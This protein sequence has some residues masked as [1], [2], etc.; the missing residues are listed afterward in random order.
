MSSI[1]KF[2]DITN[3]MIT[4]RGQSVIFDCDV[5]ELYGVET[6]EINEAVKNNPRKFPAEFFISL[7]DREKSE[8]VGK[9]QNFENN[10]FS[11]ALSQAF[12]TQGCY[13]LATLLQTDRAIGT[14]VDIIKAFEKLPEFLEII[15]KR[16]QENDCEEQEEIREKNDIRF[17]G[18]N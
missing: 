1:V 4:V 16:V 12:T 11:T 18:L 15:S 9:F 2:S 17:L 13:M 3:K 7:T 8:V 10:K 5:A 6:R 14:T